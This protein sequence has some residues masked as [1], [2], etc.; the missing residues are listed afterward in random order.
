VAE[1]A[2]VGEAGHPEGYVRNLGRSGSSMTFGIDADA[3]GPRLL[4]FH[5][6]SG[7]TRDV[8]LSLAAGVAPAIKVAAPP[9]NGE[10]R[11]FDVPVILATGTNRVVLTGKEENWESIQVDQVEVEPAAGSKP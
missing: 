8:A 3:T 7:Q 5:Y 10:W 2:G 9:T 1:L 11:T 6:L 4:R